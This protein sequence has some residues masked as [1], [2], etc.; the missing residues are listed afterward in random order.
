MMPSNITTFLAFQQNQGGV[1][2]PKL[3]AK[4]LGVSTQALCYAFSTGKLDAQQVSGI[5]YY[6]HKSLRL[7]KEMRTARDSLKKCFGSP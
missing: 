6:G 1:L 4:Y 2:P 5:T 3:A 7:Y